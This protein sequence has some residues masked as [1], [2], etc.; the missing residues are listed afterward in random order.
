M[1][2]ERSYCTEMTQVGS[3]QV[4]VTVVDGEL[5]AVACTEMEGRI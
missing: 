4:D 5:E 2:T 3:G 1:H